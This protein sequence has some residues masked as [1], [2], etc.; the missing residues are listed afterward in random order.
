[1]DTLIDYESLV[2]I[3]DSITN[4]DGQVKIE[5]SFNNIRNA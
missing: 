4:Y 1:M 5:S 3:V 2:E